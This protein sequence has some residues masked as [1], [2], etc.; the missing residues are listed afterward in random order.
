[1]RR[2]FVACT[3]TCLLST[4]PAA[5]AQRPG[6]GRPGS[7]DV[8]T[9]T[10]N[11]CEERTDK[12]VRTLR[13]A[14]RDSSLNG[15]NREDDLNRSSKELERSMDRVGRS[16]NREKDVSK[17]RQH[18]RAA[19]SD[20]RNIDITMRNRRLGGDAER[21]WRAVRIQVDLLAR[22]FSLPSVRW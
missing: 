8:I 5:W 17:T 14:L 2:F 1:M 19:I 13:R 7:I 3:L 6:L 10:I 20:A 12:F 4:V 9:R 22:A 21:E 11:D 18:V 15:T 16:W